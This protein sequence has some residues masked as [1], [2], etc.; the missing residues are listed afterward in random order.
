MVCERQV[1]FDV[2]MPSS[3]ARSLT[4]T[5]WEQ[6]R[7][8]LPDADLLTFDMHEFCH[9]GATSLTDGDTYFFTIRGPDAELVELETVTP[10]DIASQYDAGTC[11]SDPRYDT[12]SAF[13]FEC[14]YAQYLATPEGQQNAPG[15]LVAG[16]GITKAFHPKTRA[17]SDIKG[18]YG[19]GRTLASPA[20]TRVSCSA[21]RRA[22]KKETRPTSSLAKRPCSR[23]MTSAAP[24]PRRTH[25]LA[26]SRP[27]R[28][29]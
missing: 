16:Q 19:T 4:T 6:N 17:F 15:T 29:R 7:S 22:G 20:W 8:H 27:W 25:R 23:S 11:T 21:V 3:I 2:F 26:H 10:Q 24:L 1:P 28:A 13:S 9:R 18:P 12:W 5:E 14:D